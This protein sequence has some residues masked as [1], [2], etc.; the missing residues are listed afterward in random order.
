[1]EREVDISR[2]LKI[3]IAS[4]STTDDATRYS[5]RQ[6]F[7]AIIERIFHLERSGVPKDIARLAMGFVR[8]AR[9]PLLKRELRWLLSTKETTRLPSEAN[10]YKWDY[11]A[12]C[13]HGLIEGDSLNNVSFIHHTILEC[14]EDAGYENRIPPTNHELAKRC[15]YHLNSGDLD[16]GICPNPEALDDRLEKLPLLDYAARYWPHH[17][18]KTP[19]VRCKDFQSDPV[20]ETL[21]ITARKFLKQDQRVEAA[22]QVTLFMD[23]N[24]QSYLNHVLEYTPVRRVALQFKQ[25]EQKT[26]LDPF[27]Q[28]KMIGLHIACQ[29]GFSTIASEDIENNRWYPKTINRQ[30]SLDYTPL[31]YAVKGAHLEIAKALLNIGAD[32]NCRDISKASPLIL[33]TSLGLDEM[34]ELLLNHDKGALEINAQTHHD[35]DYQEHEFELLLRDGI[36]ELQMIGRVLSSVSER[37]ALHYAARN[38]MDN[39]IARLLEKKDLKPDIRD[40]EGQSA[41]HKAAKYGHCNIL[42]QFVK[43]KSDPRSRIGETKYADEPSLKMKEFQGSRSTAMHLAAKYG[44]EETVF[45]LLAEFPDMCPMQ[46]RRGATALSLATVYGQHRIVELILD[47]ADSEDIDVGINIPDERNWWPLHYAAFEKSGKCT[48]WLL[49][50]KLSKSL[51]L[52]DVED[53]ENMT[54]LHIAA[55]YGESIHVKTLLRHNVSIEKRTKNGFNA[56]ELA[57]HH[58]NWR[59]FS[60]LWEACETQELIKSDE[61]RKIIGIVER[62]NPPRHIL[63]LLKQR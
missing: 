21:H 11:I 20:S 57:V 31:H 4:R 3:I 28:N 58:K 43:Y 27:T 61:M 56:P 51:R 14:V 29:H 22:F 59:T 10:L 45:Y 24:L 7:Q 60:A 33:A 13:C 34:A 54:P 62:S 16:K 5:I 40:S 2:E 39:T 26:L 23:R 36:P 25:T 32:V 6:E 48:E 17:F 63:D 30:N 53:N 42:K 19:A 9:R 38:G 55:I 8:D 50:S 49:D 15:L 47:K 41:W 12:S 35:H 1:M 46:N 52:G 18:N 44:R 37:T